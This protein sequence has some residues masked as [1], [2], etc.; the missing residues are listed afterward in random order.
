M[1][2]PDRPLD[3]AAL[4]AHDSITLYRLTHRDFA[5]LSGSGAAAYP[6]R[7]NRLDQRALYTSTERAAAILE[8]LVHTNKNLIPSGLVMLT[9]R[10]YGNWTRFGATLTDRLTGGQVLACRS[11]VEAEKRFALAP[12]RLSRSHPFAIA[13]PSVPASVWNVVI[14]PDEP[15]FFD[16]VSIKKHRSF[17]LRPA[18]LLRACDLRD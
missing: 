7:W 11:L 18:P 17:H 5:T 12:D 10:I 13:L 3:L 8:R 14:Y 15:G 9:I 2:S 4:F 6:G 16:H 1:I